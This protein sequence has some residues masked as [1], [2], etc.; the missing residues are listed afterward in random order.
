[1]NLTKIAQEIEDLEHQVLELE[2][3]RLRTMLNCSCDEGCITCKS[4]FTMDIAKLEEQIDAKYSLM[5][6]QLGVDIHS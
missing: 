1:M 2:A 4:S 5:D 6:S 3:E